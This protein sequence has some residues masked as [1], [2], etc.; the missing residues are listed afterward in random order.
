MRLHECDVEESQLRVCL[1]ATHFGPPRKSRGGCNL[2]H[3]D[4]QTISRWS[5]TARASYNVSCGD[6]HKR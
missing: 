2:L 3:D 5:S 4:D 6:V 1:P